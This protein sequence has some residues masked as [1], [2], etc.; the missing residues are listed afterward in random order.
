MF[1]QFILGCIIPSYLL[2]NLFK[3]QIYTGL[4]LTKTGIEMYSNVLLETYLNSYPNILYTFLSPITAF[5]KCLQIGINS[6]HSYYRYNHNE[7]ISISENGYFIKYILQG[8]QYIIFI[9]KNKHFFKSIHLIEAIGY[10]HVKNNIEDELII[11]EEEQ[12]NK[13]N[14]DS[15]IEEE[16]ENKENN[17]SEIE[18]EDILDLILQLMGPDE[19]W[20][21]NNKCTPK[22]LGYIKIKLRYLNDIFDECEKY[23]IEN[24]VITF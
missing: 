19:N 9:P 20:H 16:Q 17:E 5:Y 6:I 22:D 11:E 21:N 8:E 12:E 3:E 2:F 23:V 7:N 10:S 1:S 18:E 4:E 24:E 15:I 14:N 13:E